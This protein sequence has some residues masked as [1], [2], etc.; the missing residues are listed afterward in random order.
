MALP[1]TR[2]ALQKI[3]AFVVPVGT[4]SLFGVKLPRW[5]PDPLD[6]AT[7]LEKKELLARAAGNEDPFQINAIK[8]GPGTREQPTK[9]PSMLDD[10]IIG[11]VCNEDSLYISYMTVYKGEPKRCECGHWFELVPGQGIEHPSW[12]V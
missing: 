1:V 8:R 3:S 9:V 10:R 7:G 11:C 2:A 5:G 12:W 6:L 4:R